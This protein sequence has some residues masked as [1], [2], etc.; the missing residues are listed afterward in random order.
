MGTYRVYRVGEEEA[1]REARAAVAKS[2]KKGGAAAAR[3]PSSLRPLLVWAAVAAACAVAAVLFW[4]YGRDMFGNSQA[5]F[6]LAKLSGKVPDWAFIGV[7]LIAAGIIAP[8]PCT[9][10]SAATSRSS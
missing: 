1:V 9:W 4:L 3:R 6:D 8:R 7:P 5:A 2:R 10:P